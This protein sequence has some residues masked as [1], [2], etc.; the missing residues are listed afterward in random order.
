MQRA[1]E[2]VKHLSDVYHCA[3]RY[4]DRLREVGN[5]RFDHSPW[6]N[7]DLLREYA[8]YWGSERPFASVTPVV[9]GARH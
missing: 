1:R 4:D 9:E 5:N 2:T 3:V 6:P 8:P 7:D